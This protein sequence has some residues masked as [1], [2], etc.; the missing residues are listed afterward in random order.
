MKHLQTSFFSFTFKIFP[1][2]L[3]TYFKFI[4]EIT[5]ARQPK[6]I[7]NVFVQVTPSNIIQPAIGINPQICKNF[8]L[9]K[10]SISSIV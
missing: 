6:Y 10:S 9:L 4:Q 8:L 3:F 1:I 5:V 2:Y 7:M